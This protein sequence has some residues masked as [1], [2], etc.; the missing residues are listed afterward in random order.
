MHRYILNERYAI[1]TRK[2]YADRLT[3]VM[4][5]LFLNT[6]PFLFAERMSYNQGLILNAYFIVTRIITNYHYFYFRPRRNPLI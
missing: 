5:I 2:R 1:E 3:I 4:N 6:I